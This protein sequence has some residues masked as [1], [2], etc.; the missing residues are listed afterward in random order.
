MSESIII[1]DGDLHAYL[2]GRTGATIEA[3]QRA[4]DGSMTR[5]ARWSSSA[6]LSERVRRNGGEAWE[7]TLEQ[8]FKICPHNLAE[9]FLEA[10]LVYRVMGAAFLPDLLPLPLSLILLRADL[11]SYF[12]PTDKPYRDHLP[13]QTRV[14]ALAHLMLS[15][16][17]PLR[18]WNELQEEG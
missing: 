4:F 8:T 9:R 3:L 18:L 11:H 5:S 14:A 6:L 2:L 13:D 15:G 12:T 1:T 10:T 17:L 7:K 16:R